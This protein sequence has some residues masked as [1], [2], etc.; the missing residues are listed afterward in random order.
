MKST[1]MKSLS[2]V[3]MMA[4]LIGS[5]FL[6]ARA[7]N[8]VAATPLQQT[9]Q[10]G[11][12]LKEGR[13]LLKRGHADQAL[14]RLQNALKLYTTANNPRGMA[15]TQNELGDLYLGLEVGPL[16]SRVVRRALRQELDEVVAQLRDAIAGERADR[17]E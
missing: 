15:K 16:L 9:D 11:P 12:E 7:N 3:C 4:F 5:T 14:I 2:L 17:V 1:V 13:R 10:A 8:R 6:P